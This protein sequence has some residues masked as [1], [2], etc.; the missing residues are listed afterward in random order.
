MDGDGRDTVKVNPIQS[1]LNIKLSREALVGCGEH[2]TPRVVRV[3]T[4]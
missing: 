2:K 1:I 3:E 4:A